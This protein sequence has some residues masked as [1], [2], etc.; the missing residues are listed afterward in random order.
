M[1]LADSLWSDGREGVKPTR[2]KEEWPDGK[3]ALASSQH[4]RQGRTGLNR[5]MTKCCQEQHGE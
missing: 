2:R 3:E 1:L 5:A 4:S